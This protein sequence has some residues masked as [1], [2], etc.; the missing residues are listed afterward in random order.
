MDKQRIRFTITSKG[1]HV[2]LIP[3]PGQQLP[4]YGLVGGEITMRPESTEFLKGWQEG[5]ATEV[6]A[7]VT[8]PPRVGTTA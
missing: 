3:T 2:V 1:D 7:E 8:L 5:E 6:Y 4:Y